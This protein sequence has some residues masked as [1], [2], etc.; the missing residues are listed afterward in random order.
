M[1][2]PHQPQLAG[3]M[4]QVLG[5]QGQEVKEGR[6]GFSDRSGQSSSP[7]AELPEKLRQAGASYPPQHRPRN[8]VMAPSPKSWPTAGTGLTPGLVK[9]AKPGLG[10]ECRTKPQP[11]IRP[12]GGKAGMSIS[13][14]AMAMGEGWH[15]GLPLGKALTQI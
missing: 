8:G 7:Q 11:G 9:R 14:A 15:L 1:P 10:L 6:A 4:T 3:P 2:L 12:E 5:L 13:P